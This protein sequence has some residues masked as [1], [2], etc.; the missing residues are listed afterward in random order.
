MT[1]DLT[2][3]VQAVSSRMSSVASDASAEQLAYLGSALEKTAGLMSVIDVMSAAKS[4]LSDIDQAKSDALANLS[5]QVKIVD[6]GSSYRPVVVA[7]CYAIEH[8]ETES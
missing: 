2:A 5:E 7:G 8:V 6:G 4:A 3:L 1:P